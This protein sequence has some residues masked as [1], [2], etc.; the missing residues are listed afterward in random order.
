MDAIL[1][2][3]PM[4]ATL[5]S[6]Q[7]V[8]SVVAVVAVG[9]LIQA[10]YNFF[11]DCKRQSLMKNI[12]MPP[13]R[14][15]FSH[16]MDLLAGRPWDVMMGWLRKYGSVVRFHF[17][18]TYI[19]LGD[20]DLIRHVF[21]TNYEN[22]L[23]DL[24]ASYKP[25]LDI[26]GTG[27]ITSHGDLWRKQRGLVATAFRM[28]ILGHAATISR[29]AVDRLTARLE[30]WRGTGKPIEMAEEFRHMTLQVIGEAVLSMAP[31]VADEVFPKLYLPIAQEVCC[32]HLCLCIATSPVTLCRWGNLMRLCLCDES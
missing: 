9:L 17:L 7:I 8:L 19:I 10:V 4:L 21:Q 3:V 25:F 23:K 2:R 22:Y 12:P 14:H 11:I 18:D 31:E 20:P 32:K 15:P 28:E 13:Q 6:Q 29:E 16:V 24:K 1:T 5:T 27:L 30:K 26:L